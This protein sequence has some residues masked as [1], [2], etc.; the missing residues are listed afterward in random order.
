MKLS[1]PVEI[2]NGLKNSRMPVE[3]EFVRIRV[4]LW[5]IMLGFGEPR[6]PRVRNIS[7]GLSISLVLYAADVDRYAVT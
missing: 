6:E 7:Q 4:E 3:E 2:E 5:E 1:G